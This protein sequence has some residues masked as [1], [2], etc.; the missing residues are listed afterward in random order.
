MQAHE[1]EYTESYHSIKLVYA[2]KKAIFRCSSKNEYET[3]FKSIMQLQSTSEEKRQE[4]KINEEKR[5][6][7]IA[8]GMGVVVNKQ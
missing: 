7:M 8:R 5:L 4:L 1:P 3:W 2:T 6:T